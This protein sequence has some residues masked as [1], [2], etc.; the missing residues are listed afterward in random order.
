MKSSLFYVIIA[1][2]TSAQ[3]VIVRSP[4]RLLLPFPVTCSS[5]IGPS[6]LDRPRPLH[7]IPKIVGVE[8]HARVQSAQDTKSI[9]G[10]G[11]APR[12]EALPKNWG[13]KECDLADPT[14]LSTCSQ[15]SKRSNC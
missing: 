5:V 7:A 14:S 4:S 10:G 12:H 15:H 6:P 11:G 1:L 2:L 9:L 13:L 3:D 8:W